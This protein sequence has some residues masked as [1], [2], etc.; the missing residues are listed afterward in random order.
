MTYKKFKPTG[1]NPEQPTQADIVNLFFNGL[2]NEEDTNQFNRWIN[3]L[4][5]FQTSGKDQCYFC[6]LPTLDALVQAY[7]NGLNTQEDII[8]YMR[9]VEGIQLCQTTD[10]DERSIFYYPYFVFV[11]TCSRYSED[12]RLKETS[13]VASPNQKHRTESNLLDTLV[14]PIGYE[15][16]VDFNYVIINH[17]HNDILISTDFILSPKKDHL[18]ELH[19]LGFVE[20][21]DDQ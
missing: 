12:G 15:E 3:T 13:V 19:A 7:F 4:T 17:D 14:P 21:S 16:Y 10:K 8:N 1:Y 9:W 5:M 20:A 2:E 18:A 11:S 6:L